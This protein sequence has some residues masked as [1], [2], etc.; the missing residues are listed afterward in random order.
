MVPFEFLDRSQ[1]DLDFVVDVLRY[2]NH[3]LEHFLF[4]E[5]TRKGG[6]QFF[7]QLLKFS[8]DS[9]ARGLAASRLPLRVFDIHL[10]IQGPH[11]FDQ[12][13]QRPQMLFP[14]L[15]LFIYDDAVKTFL[16]RLGNE[17]LSQ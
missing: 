13:T 4:A 12:M 7:V 3:L 5:E 17:L 14:A 2:E 9:L 10:L 11:V 16:W 15:D 6:L 8:E 1:A